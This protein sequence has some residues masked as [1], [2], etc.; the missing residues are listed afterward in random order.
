MKGCG[1]AAAPARLD[2]R[3]TQAFSKA[4][5]FF[6]PSSCWWWRCYSLVEVDGQVEVLKA[7]VSS[8]QERSSPHHHHQHPLIQCDISHSPANCAALTGS[9]HTHT[10][11][12]THHLSRP[13][14]SQCTV[15][16]FRPIMPVSVFGPH[17]RGDIAKEGEREQTALMRPHGG[18]EVHM[19][20]WAHVCMHNSGSAGLEWSTLLSWSTMCVWQS[21]PISGS[22]P[23]SHFHLAASPKS[24]CF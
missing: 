7:P 10:H 15:G 14:H 1:K 19:S 12:Y 17:G 22:S 13:S 16:V 6:P 11:A 23:S 5:I 24:L 8:S 18:L 21:F 2:K 9:K 4:S 20:V 3:I